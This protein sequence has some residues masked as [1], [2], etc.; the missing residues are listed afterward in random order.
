MPAPGSIQRHPARPARA[1]AALAVVALGACADAGPGATRG[2]SPLAALGEADISEVMLVAAGPEEAV[3][4]FQRAAADDPDDARARR[5]LALSLTRAGR[6]KAAVPVWRALVDAPGGTADDRVALADAL[7]R[8]GDWDGA[9]GT[10]GSVPPTVQTAQRYKLEAMIADQAADWARADAFYET[11]VGLTAAPAGV[12]NNWG[13]SKLSRGEPGAAERLFLRALRAEPGLFTAK[14]NL[15]LARG[16]RGL[17]ELPLV[18]MTQTERALLLHTL[19]LA[20]VKS[21]DV[22]IGRALLQDAVETHPQHFEAAA[23]ALAALGPA[24]VRSTTL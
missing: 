1:C 15:A 4:H 13:F 23:R 10:L 7:I 6:A 14:N 2:A 8:T 11:A 5:G 12:L 20:A 24:S 18:P 3:A 22:A 21:G 9:R 16:A 17:Y 19:A